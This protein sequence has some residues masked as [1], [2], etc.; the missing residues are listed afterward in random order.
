MQSLVPPAKLLAWTTWT[1]QQ[2]GQAVVTRSKRI[3]W[4]PQRRFNPNVHVYGTGR[5]SFL[6][7]GVLG[8]RVNSRN[9][10]GMLAIALAPLLDT[11][12]ELQELLF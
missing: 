11:E 12:E 5:R 9:P 4:T 10:C 6:W 3:M 2:P 1:S 7:E 8:G